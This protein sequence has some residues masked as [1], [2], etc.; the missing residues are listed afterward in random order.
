V[1][2][3]QR[4]GHLNVCRDCKEGVKSFFEKREP[5][6]DATLEEDGPPT[7]PWWIEVDTG[8]RAKV[9]VRSKAKL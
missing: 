7:Y 9:D 2:L 5:K 1:I 6:F 4:V 3:I 8:R